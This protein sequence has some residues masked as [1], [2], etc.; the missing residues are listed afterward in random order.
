[1]LWV[2][3]RVGDEL[4]NKHSKSKCNGD[5]LKN[6]EKGARKEGNILNLNK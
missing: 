4:G 1:M 2:W 5:G 6:S 3:A